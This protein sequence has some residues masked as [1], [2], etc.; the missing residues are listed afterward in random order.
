V[1]APLLVPLRP[2]GQLVAA[3]QATK[4]DKVEAEAR[5]ATLREYE[6]DATSYRAEI[7]KLR[8]R[9][10]DWQ[11]VLEDPEKDINLAR[12]LV[13]K[14]LSSPVF[15]TPGAERGVWEWS[16]AGSYEGPTRASSDDGLLP[17][18]RP[19]SR[20][21]LHPRSARPCWLGAGLGRPARW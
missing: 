5:L 10:Q 1:R 6:A 9:W 13:K 12:Q 17:L 16:A 4:A 15:V 20:T 18:R 3:L 14:L 8:D 19:R 11:G 2:E 21:R 7:V